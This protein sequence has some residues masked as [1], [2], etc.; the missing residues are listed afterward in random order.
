MKIQ[1]QVCTIEQAKKLKELGVEQK[2]LFFWYEDEKLG[3]VFRSVGMMLN[4]TEYNYSAFTAAELGVM[5][6]NTLPVTDSSLVEHQKF[7]LLRQLFPCED[8]EGYNTDYEAVTHDLE[9]DGTFFSSKGETEAISRA[10]MLIYLIENNLITA[11]K[12]NENL[13]KNIHEKA[14]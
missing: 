11:E 10:A 3:G 12:V 2:S 1:D 13:N 8:C 7:Y 6:P 9:Y 4:S 14:N 5:L